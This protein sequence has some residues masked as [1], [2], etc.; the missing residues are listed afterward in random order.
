MEKF[1]DYPRGA[2]TRD[3]YLQGKPRLGK[4]AVNQPLN[5]PCSDIVPNAVPPN[6]G[7]M[8]QTFL[9][10]DLD[11]ALSLCEAV[12]AGMFSPPVEMVVP[13]LGAARTAI[14]RNP[15]SGALQELIERA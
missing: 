12:G 2:R 15:G 5:F 8:A 1:M 6:F 10:N 14:V 11:H 4:I 7:Y 3:V 13:A 9:V